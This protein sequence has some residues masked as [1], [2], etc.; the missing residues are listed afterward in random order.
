MANKIAIYARIDESTKDRAS[1][2]VTKAKVLKN[3]TDTISKL[4]EESIEQYMINNPL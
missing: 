2:Y 1:L 4:I 3:D